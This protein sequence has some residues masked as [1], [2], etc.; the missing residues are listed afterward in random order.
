MPSTAKEY[1]EQ[2]VFQ[3]D[4]AIGHKIA[5]IHAVTGT[6]FPAKMY[7]ELNELYQRYG[8]LTYQL[9]QS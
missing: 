6:E 3:L 5:E 8:A 1:Q 4:C 2:Q 7:V 9:N